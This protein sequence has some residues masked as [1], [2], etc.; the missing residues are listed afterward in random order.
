[1]KAIERILE[2]MGVA[3]NAGYLESLALILL[4]TNE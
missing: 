3:K 4:I 2:K 1:V